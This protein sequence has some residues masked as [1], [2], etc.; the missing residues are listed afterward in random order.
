MKHSFSILS[1]IILLNCSNAFAETIT[2]S[3]NV[4]GT[5][6]ADTVL[7]VGDVR[8][9][10]DSTLT[11]EP[12]VE[13]VFRGYY[14]L[15]VNGWLSAEGTENDLILFT[16]ADTS[17]A[18]HGIRFIDA[19]DNSHLSY[20]V[21]QYGHAEGA[22]DD[23]HGGGIYCLNSNPVISWCTIQCNS[24]QDFPEG[25]GGGVYC[26]NSSPSISDCIICKNSSTKGGGLY[27]IDNSHATIIR[28]IIAEN[29]IPYY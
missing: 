9:P 10:V 15:I 21:I 19:P 22:T 14:K 17:H 27:F 16:A 29:T 1:S 18:W 23:K 26:D 25:F 28:C 11:I 7:V 12:G 20:C 13:V 2:V 24:T 6:S 3:G 4:S 5:W 8:V